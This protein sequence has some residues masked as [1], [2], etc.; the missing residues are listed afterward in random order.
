MERWGAVMSGDLGI[1]G[2]GGIET[3]KMPIVVI[4]V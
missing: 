3:N 4:I 2:W 1:V